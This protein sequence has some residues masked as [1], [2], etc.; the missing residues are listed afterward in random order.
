MSKGL[1][2]YLKNSNEI[3]DS[4][5]AI[6]KAID[7]ALYQKNLDE[8]KQLF[9]KLNKNAIP[10]N[11]KFKIHLTFKEMQDNII[12]YD[13]IIKG[14]QI[15]TIRIEIGYDLVPLV[16]SLK[17]NMIAR[18]KSARKSLS[19]ERGI[20][21]PAIRVID[22][23]N[24]DNDQYQIFIKGA[25]IDEG[26]LKINHHFVF[27]YPNGKLDLI[28]G[29]E[30]VE[31]AFKQKGKWITDDIK[32]KAEQQGYTIF[33]PLEIIDT[34]IREIAKSNASQFINRK[35]VYRL[36]EQIKLSDPIVYEE[37]NKKSSLYQ[38]KFILKKLLNDQISIRDID[39]IFEAII[40][41]LEESKIY[42]MIYDNV[43]VSQ[44]NLIIEN[45]LKGKAQLKTIYFDEELEE[46]FIRSLFEKDYHLYHNINENMLEKIKSQLKEI[47][48]EKIPKKNVPVVVVTPKIIR[49]IVDDVLY[50]LRPL[51]NVLSKEEL[52][53][54]RYFF[55]S[56][57]IGLIT[58]QRAS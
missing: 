10:P 40:D 3:R 16:N 46:Q 25:L 24:L 17:D 27:P 58:F 52:K 12:E 7:L 38:V 4:Q 9:E 54:S 44:S 22:N 57:N 2:D 21:L 45:I 37:I 47:I 34:H 18:I 56:E 13:E 48:E 49:S 53:T 51:V 31:G 42:E 32:D 23:L 33:T 36:L 20:V 30:E 55:E 8:A 5:K 35:E 1:Y 28:E 6:L 15:D 29:I 14:F 39:G 26:R 50:E 19:L 41:A 11:S 43:R